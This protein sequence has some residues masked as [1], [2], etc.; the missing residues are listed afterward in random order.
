MLGLVYEDY[1]FLLVDIGANI[2]PEDVQIQDTN[3]VTLPH[4]ERNEIYLYFLVGDDTFALRTLM[5]RSWACCCLHNII[6]IRNQV[7][8]S[9]LMDQS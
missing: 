3:P 5:M 1:E 7:A 4:S 9:A 6:M 8:Q 2:S